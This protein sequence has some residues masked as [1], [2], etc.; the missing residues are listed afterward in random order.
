MSSP[1]QIDSITVDIHRLGGTEGLITPGTQYIVL[2]GQNA[3]PRQCQ[4][5]LAHR[6][7]LRDLNSLRYPDL[8]EMEQAKAALENLAQHASDFLQSI[9]DQ[10]I[11]RPLQIDL[12]LS[13]AE[14][15][16]FPFEACYSNGAWTLGDPS[17][18]IILTRRIR[19][20]F[21]A[22]KRSWPVRPRVLFVHAPDTKDL[23]D[24]LIQQHVDA[25]EEA[26]KPWSQKGN[27]RDEGLLKV[28]M[29]LDETDLK[30]P[31]RAAREG[32]QS[33]FTHIHVLAHG[34]EIIDPLDGSVRWG[35]RL[36]YE[37][38]DASDPEDL[39]RA[40]KPDNGLP[41]VVTLAACDSGNPG[42]PSV[43]ERSF[44]QELHNQG[45]PIVIA[46][47]LPITHP[48]SVR[49]TSV[50]YEALLQGDDARWALHE[51]RRA[52]HASRIGGHDWVSVVGYVQL[53]EG[54]SDHLMDVGV[55]R[56]MELLKAARGR[57]DRALDGPGEPDFDEIETLVRTRI[58]SLKQRLEAIDLE[59]KNLRAECQGILASANKRLAELLFRRAQKTAAKDTPETYESSS[60]KLRAALDNYRAAFRAHIQNHWLG[61]QLLSLEAVLDG[62]FQDSKTWHTTFHAAELALADNEDEYWAY[63][64]LAELWLLAPF[65]EATEVEPPG[66]DRKETVSHAKAAVNQLVER[67]QDPFAIPSTRDQIA[68]YTNWWLNEHGFFGEADDLAADAE[69]LLQH[70]LSITWKETGIREQC[71]AF[72]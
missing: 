46:S 32:D 21:A 35:L 38:N 59:K 16:A 47:Q 69:E 48:G 64:T 70:L 40:L 62:A 13:A 36:G 71:D 37:G 44:A 33:P 34:K 10:E 3:P 49:L 23:P 24:R 4:M 8:V 42:R 52:L 51:A 39:A 65:L 17:R 61:A 2:A 27:P 5:P 19:R 56:E 20:G 6:D 14:L 66:Q 29:V 31:I 45:I 12:V 43:P 50:F 54:Y 72:R 55:Q 25:L 57:L 9:Q 53:P 28:E 11:K 41:V 67:A 1:Q 22:E 15:W 63:G 60:K 18:E 7:F 30:A 58:E 68:R 26:L